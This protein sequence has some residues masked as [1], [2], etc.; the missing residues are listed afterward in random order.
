MVEPVKILQRAGI[1]EADYHIDR[2]GQTVIV[3]QF[4]RV[5]E[6]IGKSW[7]S[8]AIEANWGGWKWRN[9]GRN[10]NESRS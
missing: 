9:V 4:E 2:D 1:P 3:R 7:S 6:Y 8:M 5:G 10:G